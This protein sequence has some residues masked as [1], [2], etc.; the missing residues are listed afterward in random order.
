MPLSLFPQPLAFHSFHFHQ[1]H[2]PGFT[3]AHLPPSQI[4]SPSLPVIYLAL[5]QNSGCLSRSD[6][7]YPPYF[8]LPPQRLLRLYRLYTFLFLTLKHQII[9]PLPSIASK[10]PYFSQ[11]SLFF[12]AALPATIFLHFSFLFFFHSGHHVTHLPPRCTLSTSQYRL[13]SFLTFA[14]PF[15]QRGFPPSTF[16]DSPFSY[17]VPLAVPPSSVTPT[18]YFSMPPYP[19]RFVARCFLPPQGTTGGTCVRSTSIDLF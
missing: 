1:L 14:L 6:S 11:P 2:P 18:S 4:V 5:V 10:R 12:E 19:P 13:A 3:P 16:L 7:R 9:I 8:L 15:F 17:G